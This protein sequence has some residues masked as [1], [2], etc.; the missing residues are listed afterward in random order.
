MPVTFP[1]VGLLF[2]VTRFVLRIFSTSTMTRSHTS[3]FDS[4]TRDFNGFLTTSTRLRQLAAVW[5]RS[6]FDRRHPGCVHLST[7]G[8]L[9][10]SA[11]NLQPSGELKNV[12]GK[13]ES[14]LYC[15]SKQIDLH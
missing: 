3:R 5:V 1:G 14:I 6:I 4:S 7:C 13:T 9:H 2:E 11:E 15:N 12:H 10:S 8:R